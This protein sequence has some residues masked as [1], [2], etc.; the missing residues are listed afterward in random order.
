[1]VGAI[2]ADTTMHERP[3][4]RGYVKLEEDSQLSPWPPVGNPSAIIYAHEFHYSSIDGLPGD[5]Q[6]AYRVLRGSGIT[7][8]NDGLV[9]KNLLASYTHL[10]NT[11]STPWVE[12]FLSFVSQHKAG[13]KAQVIAQNSSNRS[14]L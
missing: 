5:S 6:F 10:R 7:Q 9:Y 13:S 12:R 8:K 4:G 1:M 14:E 3:C 11:P 2:A